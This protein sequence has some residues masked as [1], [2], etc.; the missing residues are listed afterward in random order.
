MTKAHRHIQAVKELGCL[1]C[2]N[3]GL[4]YSPAD[5]HHLLR[6]GRR[7]DDFHVIP[8]CE[9]H[10]RSGHNNEVAVSRH[11]WRKAFEHRYGTEMELLEQTRKLLEKAA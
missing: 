5:A 7:I 8:L 10:H 6:N 3:T 9:K 11:P 1:V 4:G 2:R